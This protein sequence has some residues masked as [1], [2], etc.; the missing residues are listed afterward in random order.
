MRKF[1]YKSNRFYIEDPKVLE[2]ARDER[3]VVN[4]FMD[5][6]LFKTN[7]FNIT[8]DPKF[9]KGQE[10]LNFIHE[11]THYYQDLCIPSCIGERIY[12]TKIM[13]RYIDN[14]Y[15]GI[16]SS[17][18]FDE[19]EKEIYEK[20]YHDYVKLDRKNL[21]A[22]TKVIENIQFIDSEKDEFSTLYFP[23]ISYHDLLECYAEMKAWQSIICETTPTETNHD[24]IVKL[25]RKR[26]DS[27]VYDEDGEK[28][29]KIFKRRSY[30]RYSIIRVAFLAFFKYCKPSKFYL[31]QD[32]NGI[33]MIDYLLFMGQ[34]CILPINEFNDIHIKEI[35]ITGLTN[36][37]Y[38]TEVEFSLIKWIL[39][40]LDIALTIPSTN[41]I[42]ELIKSG[43]Y[44]IDDFNPCCRFYKVLAML[45]DHPYYF[46]E[47]GPSE[48]WQIIHDD[49]AEILGWPNYSFITID[50]INANSLFHYGTI[51][52]FQNELLLKRKAISMENSNG[53]LLKFFKNINIPMVVHYPNLYV[54]Y[55]Y[56]DGL[57]MQLVLSDDIKEKYYDLPI[58][59]CLKATNDGEIFL[60]QLFRNEI[61]IGIYK[62]IRENKFSCVFPLFYGKNKCNIDCISN[63]IW[64]DNPNCAMQNH[65]RKEI[66]IFNSKIRFIYGE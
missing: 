31:Y 20:I 5:S 10:Y 46:N 54:V 26:N 13:K 23:E 36:Y 33:P 37:K 63:L 16:N 59:L 50:L 61:N 17:I 64:N 24:Y 40:S 19:L 55:Y 32:L 9:V 2:F 52:F 3:R 65:I 11:L 57:L 42:C 35:D 25:L 30:E 38:L 7:E 28:A 58:N 39:F 56:Q 47:L 45:H 60:M 51:S 15:M 53:P 4:E 62:Q 21:Y 48:K 43:Q 66:S 22:D 1:T 29:V 12:K 6:L 49:M 18:P 41:K 8:E 14:H 44:N 34:N 27:F